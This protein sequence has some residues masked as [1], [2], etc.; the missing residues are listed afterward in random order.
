M[1]S[2][3]S[4]DQGG[5]P[6][7]GRRV[8]NVIYANFGGTSQ[9][10]A[11]VAQSRPVT[12]QRWQQAVGRLERPADVDFHSEPAALLWLAAAAQ[13]DE[14]RIKRGLDYAHKG[15]VVDW[16]VGNGTVRA[17]VS[18]SQPEPFDVRI[19]LPYRSKDVTHEVARLIGATPAALMTGAVSGE[20]LDILLSDHPDDIRFSCSCPD[21]VAVCKHSVAVAYTVAEAVEAQ[22]RRIF[23]F[24][25]ISVDALSQ[26][27]SE[28]GKAE[29]YSR[30]H[31]SAQS[32]WDGSG[33]PDIPQVEL[34]HAID[35]GDERLLQVALKNMSFSVHDS[36][37]GFAQLR[38][39][40][41]VL[42]DRE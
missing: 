34:S 3:N 41:T 28:S 15:H 8:D 32:F 35:D 31:S 5:Q 2:D 16:R 22:P 19:V 11:P 27:L 36:I 42:T 17:S 6:R 7:I 20:V 12:S 21:P 13:A 30:A 29:S 39:L 10:P 24:R 26:D 4:S 37:A 14:G 18:G 9:P 1:A 23:D 38:R 40:Y 33:L 25:S